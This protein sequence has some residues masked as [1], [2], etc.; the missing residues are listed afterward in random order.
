MQVENSCVTDVFFVVL[1]TV[2]LQVDNSC[3][4]DVF[5]VDTCICVCV[6]LMP[7]TIATAISQQVQGVQ[8]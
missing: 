3:V 1:W 4:T 2:V 7:N 8:R 6:H 5:F